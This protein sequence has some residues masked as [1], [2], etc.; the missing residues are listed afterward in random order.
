M[1]EEVDCIIWAIDDEEIFHYFKRI[2]A[3][4]SADDIYLEMH[5]QACV[6]W[7]CDD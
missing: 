4:E 7:S 2:E 5:A 3:G 1:D 6:E